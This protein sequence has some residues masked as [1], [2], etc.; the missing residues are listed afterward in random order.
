MDE[1]TRQNLKRIQQKTLQL[2]KDRR[3]KLLK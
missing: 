2:E 3:G 1:Q